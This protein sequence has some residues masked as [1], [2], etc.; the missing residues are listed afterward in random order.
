M[1][2]GIASLACALC[3]IALIPM[4]VLAYTAVGWLTLEW[5]YCASP[6]AIIA[7]VP[8]LAFGAYFNGRAA[9]A[10]NRPALWLGITLLL[11]SATFIV[12]AAQ[13]GGRMLG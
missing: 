8:T 1:V 12:V 2:R 9:I 6:I 13:W 4:L 7:A 11:L 10:S 5:P 3:L